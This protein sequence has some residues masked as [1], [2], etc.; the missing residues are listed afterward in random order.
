MSQS[1]QWAVRSLSKKRSPWDL[2]PEQFHF[3]LLHLVNESDKILRANTKL[4]PAFERELYRRSVKLS[5]SLKSSE[6]AWQLKYWRAAHLPVGFLPPPP[7]RVYLSPHSNRLHAYSPLASASSIFPKSQAN[8][9]HRE[10]N[11][12]VADNQNVNYISLEQ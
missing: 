9:S 2:S 12:L 11:V 6:R 5:A 1:W 7:L 4:V 3:P 8:E 10:V